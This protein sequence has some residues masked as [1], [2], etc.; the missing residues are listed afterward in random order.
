MAG[1]L[2]ELETRGG[3]KGAGRRLQS[4]PVSPPPT[5]YFV[6]APSYQGF[7]NGLRPH[8]L[9]EVRTASFPGLLP[10]PY[11]WALRAGSSSRA[12]TELMGAVT[13]RP[14]G[15]QSQGETDRGRGPDAGG[16]GAGLR[17]PQTRRVA[18]WGQAAGVRGGTVPTLRAWA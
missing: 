18:P 7:C 1:I 17:S 11:P 14:T 5:L 3:R 12:G 16:A 4:R 15:R 9:M 10:G 6:R 2:R 8:G 13:Q